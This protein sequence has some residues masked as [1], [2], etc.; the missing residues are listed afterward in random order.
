MTT[1]Q[2]QSELTPNTPYLACLTLNLWAC[3]W[4]AGFGLAGNNI[5]GGILADQMNWGGNAGFYNTII[6]SVAIAG[7][8]LGSLFAGLLTVHGRRK[9]L[10][11]SN[12]MVFIATACVMV[13]NFYTILVGRFI[14]GFSAGVI[15]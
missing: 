14:L 8:T 3:C 13:L 5:V 6:S 10:I 7:M 11:I 12:Y 4:Q 9:A 15:L 2:M 1:N